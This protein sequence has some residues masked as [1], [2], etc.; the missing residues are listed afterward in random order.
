[1]PPGFGAGL[2]LSIASIYCIFPC[3]H[4]IAFLPDKRH[5]DLLECWHE[6]WQF[7][8]RPVIVWHYG[9]HMSEFHL[10]PKMSQP[11][12]PSDDNADDEDGFGINDVEYGIRRPRRDVTLLHRDSSSLYPSQIMEVEYYLTAAQH[13]LVMAMPFIHLLID[14]ASLFHHV[15]RLLALLQRMSSPPLA[16]LRKLRGVVVAIKNNAAHLTHLVTWVRSHGEIALLYAGDLIY[17]VRDRRQRFQPMQHRR[18][19]EISRSDCDLW[20]GLTPFQMRKLFKHLRIPARLQ[21]DHGIH[22]HNR[23]LRRRVYDDEE[24]TSKGG[25]TPSC[26]VCWRSLLWRRP[27]EDIAHKA[28]HLVAEVVGTNLTTVD[29]WITHPRHGG[30]VFCVVVL[31]QAF[32]R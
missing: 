27:W 19:S 18:I 5:Y 9:R 7:S 1:M 24:S 29:G 12:H 6:C 14:H 22:H 30:S 10:A 28:F 3:P 20:F 8:W 31:I 13:A 11:S 17:F 2:D 15:S 26:K 25:T 4:H 21:R 32:L 16:V 23:R